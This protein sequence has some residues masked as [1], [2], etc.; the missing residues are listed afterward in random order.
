MRDYLKGLIIRLP[1]QP[2]ISICLGYL[3][4]VLDKNDESQSRY[5]H[6]ALGS[7]NNE[8][9]FFKKYVNW[10]FPQLKDFE[11]WLSENSEIAR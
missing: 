8:S 3:E 5:Y 4:H 6:K 7:L 11:S 1:D 9:S 10:D 2:I